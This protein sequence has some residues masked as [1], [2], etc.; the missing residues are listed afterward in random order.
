MKFL[1]KI[2]D[3]YINASIHVA[4]AAVAFV[5]ITEIYFDLPS[6]FYFDLFVLFGTITGYNFVK[7][8]GVAKLHHRSLTDSL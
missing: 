6:N 5:K 2:F 1:Q 8:A 7:F 4:L 3:F